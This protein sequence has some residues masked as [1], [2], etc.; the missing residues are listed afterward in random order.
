M[1]HAPDPWFF[2]SLCIVFITALI[3]VIV[4]YTNKIDATLAKIQEMLQIHDKKIAVLEDKAL[5]K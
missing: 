1:E 4:R 5:R 2:Y 3:W